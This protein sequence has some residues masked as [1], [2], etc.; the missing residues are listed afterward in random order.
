[1]LFHFK[2]LPTNDYEVKL[3][4]SELV[5]QSIRQ[6][7]VPGSK[8]KTSWIE[9]DVDQY[10]SDVRPFKVLSNDR[11]WKLLCGRQKK[12]QSWSKPGF[13]FKSNV[14]LSQ[15]NFTIA[16]VLDVELFLVWMPRCWMVEGLLEEIVVLI[17]SVFC[18][19]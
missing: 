10:F 9:T 14:T 1:M 19:E 6:F 8:N 13:G 12:C 7:F 15:H 3:A 17:C 18:T 2:Y 16:L 11:V 4:A 5:R